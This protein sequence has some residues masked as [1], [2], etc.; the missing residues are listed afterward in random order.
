MLFVMPR[1]DFQRFWMR[2]MQFPIDIIWMEQGRVVGCEK[3][4]SPKDE[5][6]FASPSE[7]SAVLEVLE[8]FCDHFDVQVNDPVGIH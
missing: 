3:N 1:S 4:I 6:V 8:G 2:G 7:A 5:R